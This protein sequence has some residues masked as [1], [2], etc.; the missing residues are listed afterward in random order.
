LEIRKLLDETKVYKWQVAEILGV[1]PTTLSI[2]L[3]HEITGELKDMIISAI[4]T[5]AAK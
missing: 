5:A 2:A 1:T 3:R 4:K